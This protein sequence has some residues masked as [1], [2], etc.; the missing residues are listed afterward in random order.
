M[1]I[2]TDTS[3]LYALLNRSDQSHADAVRVERTIR[4]QHEIIWTL[5]AVIAELWRLLRA[6]IGRQEAD[7]LVQALIARGVDGERAL[8]V[9]L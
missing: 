1:P 6:A 7:R 2:F 3:A 4:D 5:D 8:D 9:L